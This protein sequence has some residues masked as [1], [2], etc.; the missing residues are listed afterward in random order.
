MSSV[1]YARPMY[2]F[3]CS[4]YIKCYENVLFIKYCCVLY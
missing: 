4:M 3:A 1:L 2:M